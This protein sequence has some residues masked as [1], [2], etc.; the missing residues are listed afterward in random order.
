V[1]RISDAEPA[2]VRPLETERIS[3]RTCPSRTLIS[4]WPGHKAGLLTQISGPNHCVQEARPAWCSASG[5]AVARVVAFDQ[6][7]VCEV[8]RT[9]PHDHDHQA[10]PFHGNR[11][12]RAP[13]SHRLDGKWQETA[14]AELLDFDVF[15]SEVTAVGWRKVLVLAGSS[16]SH[17]HRA[18]TPGA[19]GL[20]R[21]FNLALDHISFRHGT[22]STGSFV[23]T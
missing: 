20:A 13:I 17:F 5:A 21:N 15:N 23:R 14:G 19:A 1:A 18:Q 16:E 6:C 10:T 11:S 7:S 9:S 3:N 8:R 12:N 2:D 4:N 22:G